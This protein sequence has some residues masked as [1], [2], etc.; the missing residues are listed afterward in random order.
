VGELHKKEALLKKKEFLFLAMLTIV[1]S[2]IG[3]CLTALLLKDQLAFAQLDSKKEIIAETFR[4]IDKKG[5]TKALLA[6]QD[7]QPA[8]IF[9]DGKTLRLFIGI[10]SGSIPSLIFYNEKMQQLAKLSAREKDATLFISNPTNKNV[11]ISMGLLKNTP[12]ILSNNNELSYFL[13]TEEGAFK[14][15]LTDKGKQYFGLLVSDGTALFIGDEKTNV[16]LFK[17]HNDAWLN[18]SKNGHNVW[19]AP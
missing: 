15:N 19:S 6:T 9:S 8:L 14:M 11:S 3:G 10:D 7:G 4:L 17:R 5:E 13:R 16:G 1:F 18:V 12:Y 2:L